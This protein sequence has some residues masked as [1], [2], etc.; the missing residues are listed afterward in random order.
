MP[1]IIDLSMTIE[2]HFRWPVE[3][4]SNSDHT[5][6]DLFQATWLRWPVHGF[7]HMD[8]PRHFFGPQAKYRLRPR[9]A[10]RRWST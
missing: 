9:S 7:T 8:S 4:R 5:E 3:R 10:R 6:G 1:R 2:N